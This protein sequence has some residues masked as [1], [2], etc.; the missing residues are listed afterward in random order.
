MPVFG[1]RPLCSGSL[2]MYQSLMS[3]FTKEAISSIVLSLNMRT[4]HRWW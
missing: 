4:F 3:W 2:L 1:E